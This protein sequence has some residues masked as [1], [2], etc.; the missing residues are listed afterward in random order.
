MY[1]ESDRDL[2]TEEH[3]A[4]DFTHVVNRRR[5]LF[6]EEFPEGPYGAP[7]LEDTEDGTETPAT[8]T[9]VPGRP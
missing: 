2:Q 4:S 6:P 9:R 1:P 3:G 5:E 7:P 8:S